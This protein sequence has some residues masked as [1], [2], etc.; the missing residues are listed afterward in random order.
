MNK[1][2]LTKQRLHIEDY[3]YSM[4]HIRTHDDERFNQTRLNKILKIIQ[5]ITSMEDHKNTKFIL[6]SN[7]DIYLQYIKFSS[8]QHTQLKNAHLGM[9]QSNIENAQDTMIEFMLASTSKKIYQL[10]VYGWGSGFSDTI[11]NVYSV[12]IEHFSIH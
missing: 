2:T 1:V 10:S 7:N 11:R 6:I 12:P 5:F 9:P 8:I 4:I 3:A